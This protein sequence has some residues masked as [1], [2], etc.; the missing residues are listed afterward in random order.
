MYPTYIVRGLCIFQNCDC[1]NWNWYI[2][3]ISH[4]FAL[5]TAAFVRPLSWKPESKLL[6]VLRPSKTEPALETAVCAKACCL[7]TEEWW[8]F[9]NYYASL[10][11]SIGTMWTS[12]LELVVISLH[13][14]LSFSLVPNWYN[15]DWYNVCCQTDIMHAAIW[16][17]V[18]DLCVIDIIYWRLHN[19]Y[20]HLRPS[21]RAAWVELR[22]AECE[23][24][25]CDPDN[26]CW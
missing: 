5:K 13:K 20:Q 23:D 3:L 1:L 4:T 14:T 6:R 17:C 16:D 19:T 12:L 9:C 2:A 24:C 7:K 10:N 25:C 8:C 26:C 18:M 21:W 15:E 22:G 11:F